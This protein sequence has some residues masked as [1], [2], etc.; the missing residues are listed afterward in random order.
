MKS[1]RFLIPGLAADNTASSG[2]PLDNRR[3]RRG[4]YADA[5]GVLR[6]RCP[7]R[8]RRRSTSRLLDRDGLDL[9]EVGET[10]ERLEDAVL[11]ERRH[12][13]GLGLLQHLGHTRLRLDEPLH[14]VGRDE[15]LVDTQAAA[16]AGLVARGATFAAIE[17]ERAVELL[18]EGR[19]CLCAERLGQL[20]VLGARGMVS[21]AAVLA[22]ALAEPL[23]E[24]A[25]QRVG[26]V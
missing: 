14:L 13:L 11:H 15:E 9:P 3:A 10:A 22:D 20:V 8:S 18:V 17:D 1:A 24:D 4:I 26:E 23:A 21:V 6:E 12:A 25:E 2:G 16:I 19:E 5:I 7:A